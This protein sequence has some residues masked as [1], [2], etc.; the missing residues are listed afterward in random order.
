V[1]Q[2]GINKGII[3]RCMAYQISRRTDYVRA[4]S[5][6]TCACQLYSVSCAVLPL[7][8]SAD[9]HTSNKVRYLC[10]RHVI[11]RHQSSETANTGI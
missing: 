1:Y 7:T 2:V 10:D 3:L 8:H 11:K 9:T 5:K 6:V 4:G